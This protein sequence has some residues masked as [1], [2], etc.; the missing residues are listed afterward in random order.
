M[1]INFIP[2]DNNWYDP[3]AYLPAQGWCII[4]IPQYRSDGTPSTSRI[5]EAVF[6]K[7]YHGL[8]NVFV[9]EDMIDESAYHPN[10]IIAW[11]RPTD[12][13]KI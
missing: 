1:T 8:K 3:S 6:L 9:I 7:D 11:M 2:P 4:A 5:D 13:V 10:E 12:P